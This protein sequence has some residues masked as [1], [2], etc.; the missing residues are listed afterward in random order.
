MVE[1]GGENAEES[2]TRARAL[3]EAAHTDAV[4]VYPPGDKASAL[5][6]IRADGAGLGGR[7]PVDP[8]TGRGNEQA[9]PGLEDAAV[10]P[11]KLGA[12]LRE[13]NALCAEYDIDGLLFGHFGDGCVHVRLNLPLETEAGVARSRRF[14]EESARLIARHGGSVSG[15]H[16]DGRARS[17]LYGAAGARCV[18]WADLDYH[19]AVGNRAWKVR[20]P[21]CS[22]GSFCGQWGSDCWYRTVVY[23]RVT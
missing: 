13:F 11:E 14:L 19:G 2:L 10:P 22:F 23:S 8:E 15:E 1:M 16:G 18:L 3:A 21:S 12:Y 9:W 17:E 6:R 5:W 7:T 4:V 20:G